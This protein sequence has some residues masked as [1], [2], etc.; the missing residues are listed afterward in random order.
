MSGRQLIRV[1]SAVLD[2]LHS[3]G[4][5]DGDD[6]VARLSAAIDAHLDGGDGPIGSVEKAF[7]ST[8]TSQFAGAKRGR[9]TKAE[10]KR[11]LI[12][13]L[14]RIEPQTG[15]TDLTTLLVNFARHAESNLARDLKKDQSEALAR[16]TLDSW[17]GSHGKTTRE[18]HEGTGQT[19][20]LFTALGST[21]VDVVEVKVPKSNTEFEDGITEVAQYA[22]SM[23]R[24]VAYYVV[25]DHCADLTRPR[26]LA[27]EVGTVA[28]DGVD[29]TCVRVRVAENPPSGVGRARRRAS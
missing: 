23:R 15:P 16:A 11:D 13:R 1:R 4:A 26:F 24:P 14:A 20:L 19:D 25:F 12:D 17:L 6:F 5:V 9:L 28:R 27:A 3:G 29:V 10:F 2:T 18:S 22:Q 21:L 8:S 7:R